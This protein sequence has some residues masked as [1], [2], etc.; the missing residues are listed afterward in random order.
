MG[1][2]KMM[3]GKNMAERNTHTSGISLVWSVCG[4]LYASATASVPASK[5][6]FINKERDFHRFVFQFAGVKYRMVS[7]VRPFLRK[8]LRTT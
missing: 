1:G 8:S 6:T 2:G 5:S 7:E 3:V 4:E